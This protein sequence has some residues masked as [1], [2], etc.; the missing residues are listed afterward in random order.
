MIGKEGGR[1]EWHGAQHGQA[2]TVG[3]N[4]NLE[5]ELGEAASGRTKSKGAKDGQ[6]EKRSGPTGMRLRP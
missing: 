2:S 5:K 1:G 4:I 3:P 6:K